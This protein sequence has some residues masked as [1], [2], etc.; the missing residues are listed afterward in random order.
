M[1]VSRKGDL[2][3]KQSKKIIKYILDDRYK[4]LSAYL[5]K[6]D[7]PLNCIVNGKG[8][9]MVHVCCREGA[10]GC[11]EYLVKAG[12]KVNLVDKSG[13]LAIHN[14]IKYCIE[15]FSWQLE[16]DLVSFLLTYSSNLLN[17]QNNR[18]V[19]AK[20]LLDQLQA[21]KSVTVTRGYSPEGNAYDSDDSDQRWQDRLEEECDMEYE[22]LFG[23]KYSTPEEDY[24][25]ADS[26][27]FDAWADRI[28]SAFSNRRKQLYARPK[29]TKEKKSKPDY[30]SSTSGSSSSKPKHNFKPD[31]SD[32]ASRQN[33]E[34]LRQAKR[35]KKIEDKT[36]KLFDSEEEF[37]ISDLPYTGLQAT[38]ILDFMLTN[39]QGEKEMKKC[40]REQLLRWHPDKFK[41]KMASR[42]QTGELEL[43]MEEVKR[44]AQAVI[45]FAK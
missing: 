21:M 15:N 32:E 40:I 30:N 18:G 19:S 36:K 16:K 6:E 31:T 39:R 28:Y 26:E 24:Y 34:K 4:K 42:V 20:S 35:A 45:G 5:E 27:S 13:N 9:K 11:L 7:I 14:A 3:S 17:I 41:Q 1:E 38:E 44:I 12:A 8:E 23:S 25:S 43:V 10:T 29:G 22:N 33:T 37:G 2:T